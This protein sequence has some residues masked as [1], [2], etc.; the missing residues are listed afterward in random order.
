MIKTPRFDHTLAT[1]TA[2]P[3]PTSPS[4][5]ADPPEAWNGLTA[6][7]NQRVVLAAMER[8]VEGALP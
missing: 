4:H 3:K 2:Q 6:G 1:R 8:E 7:D 5:L